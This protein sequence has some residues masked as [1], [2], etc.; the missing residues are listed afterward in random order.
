M[1]LSVGAMASGS[2]AYGFFELG[3]GITTLGAGIMLCP[4]FSKL[5]GLM[6]KLFNMFFSWLKSLFSGKERVR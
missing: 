3:V 1:G 5:V 4:L 2:A 6:W